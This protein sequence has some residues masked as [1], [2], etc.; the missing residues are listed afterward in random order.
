VVVVVVEFQTQ[1]LL[2]RLTLQQE[3]GV[4]NY[5]VLLI[6]RREEVDLLQPIEAAV[7]VAGPTT[8]VVLVVLVVQVL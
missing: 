1:H 7:V 4:M 2:P 5:K 6:Q 3:R 8:A